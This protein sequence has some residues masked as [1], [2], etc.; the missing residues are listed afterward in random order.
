MAD[1]YEDYFRCGSCRHY[2][3]A[4]TDRLGRTMGQ[5]FRKPRRATQ[6][7][8]DMACEDYRMDRD[9]LIPG[10]KV[11]DNAPTDTPRER[12]RR[13]ALQ[14]ATQRHKRSESRRP[15]RPERPPEKPKLQQIPL[16]DEGDDMDRDELK[17]LLAEV[18]DEALAM[19]DP[20]LH[21][22]YRGGKVV[23]QPGNGE[24]SSKEVPIDVF[25]RK[26]TTVRDKLRVLEQKLNGNKALEPE[27]RA[28]LQGYISGCY[29]ALK[30]FNMLFADRDDWFSN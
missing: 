14:Q 23:I 5:C 17:S 12:M 26:I 9:R 4:F 29:G 30:T 15:K 19:S 22:R 20:P 6:P 8:H 28:Q 27:E 7:A 3:V 21:P 18:I 24:L 10:A 13:Q 16:G 25:F 11:P 1:V 2:E